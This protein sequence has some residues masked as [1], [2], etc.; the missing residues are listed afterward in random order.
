MMTKEKFPGSRPWSDLALES[1][2]LLHTVESG[3]EEGDD[4]DQLIRDQGLEV[5]MADLKETGDEET[6][7][8][9]ILTKDWQFI[10]HV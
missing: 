6:G 9:I 5:A 2:G 8:M 7:I 4:E 10:A 3:L 1:P